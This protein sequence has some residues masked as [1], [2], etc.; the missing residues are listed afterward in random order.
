MNG[1]YLAAF[2][3]RGVLAES[4][5]PTDIDDAPLPVPA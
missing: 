5:C 3:L 1:G 2:C 4:A